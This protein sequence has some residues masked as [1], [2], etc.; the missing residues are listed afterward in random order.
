MNIFILSTGRCGSNTF[1]KASQHIM[2]YSSAHESRHGLIGDERL[3]YP[4]NHIE[5]DNRLSWFYCQ[6]KYRVIFN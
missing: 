4:E 2:N 5:A 3:K 6:L 1:I